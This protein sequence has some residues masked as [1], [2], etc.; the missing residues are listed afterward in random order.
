MAR[1]TASA[2]PR[3]QGFQSLP[4]NSRI[5]GEKLAREYWEAMRVSIPSREFSDWWSL[6]PGKVNYDSPPSFNPFQG[7]LGLVGGSVDD[8]EFV[9][10]VFQSLPGN[11]RIGGRGCCSLHQKPPLPVSIPSREF[12]DW[13]DMDGFSGQK[14]IYWFQSLPGNSRIG[15]RNEFDRFKTH[16]QEFQSL[17]GNSRIGGAM[18]VFLSDMKFRS[19]NPF[20]GILG[21]VER[22]RQPLIS[23]RF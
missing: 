7:I 18:V 2:Y 12:S 9:S 20:Q 17:P 10:V 15:G 11:S 1:W 19:F 23:E 16:M 8:T 21:L 4:G 13:W 3:K 5:G 6:F 22:L 14:E